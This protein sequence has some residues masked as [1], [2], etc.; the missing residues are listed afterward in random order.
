M[1]SEEEMR[2]L[3]GHEFPGGTYAIAHWEN[4]LMTEATGRHPLP[5]GL[6]HPV[7]L[8]H[9]PIAG[10]GV[11][12]ADLFALGRAESDASVGID[13]YDWEF[14]QP[15][16][17]DEVYSMTGGVTEYAR[18]KTDGGGVVD[19]VTFSIEL[20]RGDGEPVARVTFRWFFRR[21]EA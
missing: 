10:A 15:L 1:V 20:T 3:V 9:V 4:F 11:S 17:E 18:E 12:I 5:D 21:Q 19:A 14:L 8:F 6:A 7:H 13:Y 16:Y 2:A